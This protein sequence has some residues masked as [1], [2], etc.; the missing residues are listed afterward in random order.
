M[1]FEIHHP[2]GE[3]A[4]YI[5]HIVYYDGYTAE[6]KADKLLPD[7]GVYVII[8]MLEK[9]NKLYK[10]ESLT[11]HKK[12]TGC[13]ISGQHKGYIFIEANHSSNMA[14]R[15][16][17]G[18]VAPFIPIPIAT[19]NNKVQQLEPILG[20]SVSAM[21]KEVIAAQSPTDK[22]SIVE[23]YFLS[24][25]RKE[26]T[27]NI[28]FRNVLEYMENNAHVATTAQLASQMNVS[29]KH[30]IALFAKEVGLTPKALIRIFR[31]QKV[32]AEL[33]KNKKIDWMQ[34]ATDNG[35]YDQAHFVKDFY[36]FSGIKPTQ[37]NDKRGD[38]LNY[39]P[40]N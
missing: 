39:L 31:F 26:Y 36:A 21:R 10:N 38:Y 33:E 18:G 17:P 2:K 1:V 8:N 35:Y 23:N 6:H 22:F 32:I 24:I 37:Y 13:F 16:R 12:F 29:Q 28:P 20:E 7:G 27:D 19:L 4:K 15:F 30:L 34:V 11:N 14:V 5:D 25:K 3:L 40:V 9:P